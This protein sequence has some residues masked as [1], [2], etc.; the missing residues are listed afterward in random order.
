MTYY[1]YISGPITN[2]PDYMQKFQACEDW[3][4]KHTKYEPV[5]PAK[6]VPE[7]LKL[8]GI[9]NPTHNDYM[10]VSINILTEYQ[11]TSI[12]MLGGWRNSK[13]SCYEHKISYMLNYKI[14]WFKKNNMA[15]IPKEML[16]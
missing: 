6:L 8:D 2:D 11:N 13:G 12:V 3:I 4:R 5:N 1:L 10:R 14:M 16:K 9:E 7:I 15:Y